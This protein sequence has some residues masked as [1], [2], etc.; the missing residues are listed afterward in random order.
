MTSGMTRQ[1]GMKARISVSMLF[2][3]SAR[4]I[5]SA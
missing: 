5:A 3:G 4:A 2:S 1:V